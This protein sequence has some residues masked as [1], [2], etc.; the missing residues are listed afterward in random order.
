MFW[1]NRY[2]KINKEEE[3]YGVHISKK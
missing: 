2:T 1:Y 3:I